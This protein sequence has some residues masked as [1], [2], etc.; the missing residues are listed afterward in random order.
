MPAVDG[1]T[2]AGTLGGTLL[3]TLVNLTGQDLLET[4]L[5]AAVGAV[6]SFVVSLT[7][8]RLVRGKWR[9]KSP[10]GDRV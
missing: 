9:K 5:L 6:V 7:L 10:D 8:S 1:G 4:G 2:R 3:S